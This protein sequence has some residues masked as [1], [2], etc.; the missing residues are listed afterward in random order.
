MHYAAVSPID[1]HTSKK[2]LLK[3]AGIPLF[4][5]S[6]LYSF[7]IPTRLQFLYA[8]KKTNSC[9]APERVLPPHFIP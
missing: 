6:R 7:L 2:G 8:E 5:E 1:I 3:K 4:E 9:A